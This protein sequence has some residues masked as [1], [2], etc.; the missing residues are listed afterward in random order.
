STL[1]SGRFT[2]VSGCLANRLSRAYPALSV[3]SS[4]PHAMSQ[5]ATPLAQRLAAYSAAAGVALALAPDAYAQ[6]VYNDFDPDEV[7]GVGDTFGLD[8]DGD[9]TVDLNFLGNTGG[10]PNTTARFA[11]RIPPG[12][13]PANG[14]LGVDDV[15]FQDPDSIGAASRLG[16]GDTIGPVSLPQGFYAYGIVASLYAAS[17]YYNFVGQEGYAG[18]RFVAGGGTTHY[19]WIRLAINAGVTEGTLFEYAYEETP[20]TPILAGDMG[21]VAIEPGP[22]GAPGTHAL[23][24]PYPNPARGQAALSLEVAETQHVRVEV[25]DALG[26]RVALLHDAALAA[27]TEHRLTLDGS[28]LAAG[29]YVVRAVGERFSDLR[30]LTLTR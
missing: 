23:S 4:T 20:D 8:F 29:V 1:V 27:G 7:I 12:G 5:K 15:Y 10:G 3:P 11:L 6:I 25:Y 16:S 9:G 13:N 26:K 22:D 21:T 24:A 14:V 2:L 30:T 17:P 18:F 19:G 28:G